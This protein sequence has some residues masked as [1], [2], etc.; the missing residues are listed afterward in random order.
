MKTWYENYGEDADGN[1]GV[2]TLMY[3]LENTDEE[4]SD[5][6]QILY[7]FNFS[8]EDSGT[9]EIEYDGVNIEVLVEDYS[10]ELKEIEERKY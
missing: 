5:I 7:D 6:S 9:T 1:R 10:D 8:S 2:R 4:K 3:E